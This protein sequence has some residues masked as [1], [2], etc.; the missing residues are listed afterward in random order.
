MGIVYRY[1]HI[2]TGRVY[3]GQ[4][5]CA[6]P[7][8][9]RLHKY[10]ALTLKLNSRFY[11]ALRDLGIDSFT[12]DVIDQGKTRDEL[13]EKERLWIAR[14]GST[15]PERGFNTE[16]GGNGLPRA[17]ET[18]T[19]IRRNRVWNGFTGEAKVA[20]G[21]AS[22][23]RWNDPVYR[24]KMSEIQRATPNHYSRGK[25]LPDSHRGKISDSIR[26]WRSRRKTIKGAQV[27]PERP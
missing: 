27:I 21:N 14:Y 7:V 12:V 26:E 19:K 2:P 18:I 22:R 8:R 23:E 9:C 5:T 15:E 20:I 25:A 24:Q 6:L 16:P 13:W 1:T 17:A 4:T 3:I 10:R 11:E